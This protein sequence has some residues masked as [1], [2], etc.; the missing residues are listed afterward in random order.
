[1]GPK[2]LSRR[3]F[4]HRKLLSDWNSRVGNVN[5]ACLGGSRSGRNVKLTA[6]LYRVPSLGLC[7]LLHVCCAPP[8]YGAYAEGKFI[9][10]F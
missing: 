3:D 5:E 9:L 6:H 10:T 4:S 8:W 7:V 2:K 1:M